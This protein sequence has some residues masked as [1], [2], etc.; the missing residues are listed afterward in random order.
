[1]STFIVYHRMLDLI[2]TAQ[3]NEFE[4]SA[5]SLYVFVHIAAVVMVLLCYLSW[6]LQGLAFSP[7][8]L[9]CSQATG[10]YNDWKLCLWHVN[11]G[12]ETLARPEET[13]HSCILS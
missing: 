13:T 9:L 2:S 8:K 7:W 11:D 12:A 10:L 6:Q 3:N 1:M 4:K 5:C